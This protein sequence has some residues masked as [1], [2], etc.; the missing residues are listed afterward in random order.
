MRQLFATLLLLA[1]LDA[2]QAMRV[3]ARVPMRPAVSR[4]H[5]AQQTMSMNEDPEET[6]V[7]Q[8]PPSPP[9]NDDWAQPPKKKS[10]DKFIATF[11]AVAL[12]GYSLLLVVDAIINGFCIPFVG[13]LGI[14]YGVQQLPTGW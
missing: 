6:F 2:S 7:Q 4:V 13:N 9:P 12:G 8:P 1:T 14:C 3:A 10:D 11:V 5:R